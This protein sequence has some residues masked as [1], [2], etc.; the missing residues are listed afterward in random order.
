MPDVFIT[1]EAA[2][3]FEGITYEAKMCIRDRLSI[4]RLE[5]VDH[6]AK[7]HKLRGADRGEIR[8]MGEED[9]PFAGVILREFDRALVCLLYTSRCV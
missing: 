4:E 1:L 8:G 6:R 2:A 5:L 9:H 3:A 7:G